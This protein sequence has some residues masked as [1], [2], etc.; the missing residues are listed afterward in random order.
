LYET[1]EL[2][3]QLDLIRD[4]MVAIAPEVTRHRLSLVRRQLSAMVHDEDELAHLQRNAAADV[5]RITFEGAMHL[6]GQFASCYDSMS[7][8]NPSAQ[9]D[10]LKAKLEADA[11]LQ[12][13]AAPPQRSL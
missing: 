5:A 2:H 6:A 8:T 4:F 9:K 10:S 7:E 11:A 12:R 3:S 13:E 1:V